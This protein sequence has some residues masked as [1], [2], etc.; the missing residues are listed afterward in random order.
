MREKRNLLVA[1][2]CMTAAAA[3]AEPM[4]MQAGKT[5]DQIVL[6]VD[7]DSLRV[8]PGMREGLTNPDIRASYHGSR[9]GFDQPYC[10]QGPVGA[11]S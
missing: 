4:E 1:L 3:S 2:L 8:G 11:T 10:R 5:T 7:Y 6:K 9:R